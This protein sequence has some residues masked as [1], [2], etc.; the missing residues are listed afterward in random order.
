MDNGLVMFR[1]PKLFLIELIVIVLSITLHEFGHAI[2]ADRLG[3]DT[4]RRQGRVTLWPDK[5]FDPIGFIMIL[6]TLN[7]GR[8]LGWGKPVMVNFNRLRHPRRDMLLVAIFGPIMNLILA[9][10]AGLIIRISLSTHHVAWMADMTTGEYST[11]GMF[12]DAFLSINLGLMFFNLIPIHPLDGSKI[13]SSLLPLDHAVRYDRFMGQ[14][15]P[16][17]IMLVCFVKPELLGMVI[18]PAI[19]ST[20]RILI[21]A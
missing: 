10:I 11:L 9:V 20:T 1:D 7:F 4:P 16:M 6:V 2:S 3:D 12:V 19:V 21:G 14:F 8:G 13:L 17:I 15:G 5:H 18:G